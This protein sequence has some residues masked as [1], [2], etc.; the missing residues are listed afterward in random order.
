MQ[1]GQ[2]IPFQVMQHAE[3]GVP[4]MFIDGQ[5]PATAQTPATPTRAT[6]PDDMVQWAILRELKALRADLDA[7]SLEGRC[8]RIW[9][10][11]KGRFR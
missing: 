2:K 10:W 6:T 7:R 11:L 4:V 9:R 1:H 3:I 8:R 5:P